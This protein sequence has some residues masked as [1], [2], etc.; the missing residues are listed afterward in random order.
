MPDDR[1]LR[2]RAFEAF[3]GSGDVALEDLA[4]DRGRDA[5]PHGARDEVEAAIQQDVATEV[6]EEIL[7]AAD[8][9]EQRLHLLDPGDVAGDGA[10]ALGEGFPLVEHGVEQVVVADFDDVD[11]IAQALAAEA[12]VLLHGGVEGGDGAGLFGRAVHPSLLV[13]AD[14]VDEK[15][16]VLHGRSPG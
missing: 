13:A 11:E 9:V 6:G 15:D 8:V 7:V 5:Q 14:A 12:G 4:R 1:D 2:E 10:E 16:D 3:A